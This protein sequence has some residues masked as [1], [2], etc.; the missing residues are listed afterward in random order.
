[1]NLK[2]NLSFD[3]QEIV[4]EQGQSPSGQRH[5]TFFSQG[6]FPFGQGQPPLFTYRDSYIFGWY[7][8]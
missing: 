2:I 4:R 1:M 6:Q 7:T 8:N 3:M 5:P